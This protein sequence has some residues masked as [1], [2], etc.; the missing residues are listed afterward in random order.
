MA[1][2]QQFRRHYLKVTERSSLS[3]TEEFHV[4][5]L[6]DFVNEKEAIKS[7]NFDLGTIRCPVCDTDFAIPKELEKVTS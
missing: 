1:D 5:Q 4:R 3:P 2:F 6:F 7:T